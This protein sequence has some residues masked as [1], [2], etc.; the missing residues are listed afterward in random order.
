MAV[1][2][3]PFNLC[4]VWHLKDYSVFGDV[5]HL[6]IWLCLF[7]LH[8]YACAAHSI[9]LGY[10]PCYSHQSSRSRRIHGRGTGGTLI[11]SGGLGNRDV[12]M[13]RRK[14]EFLDGLFFLSLCDILASW[15]EW[16][17][18]K[19]LDHSPACSLHPSMHTPIC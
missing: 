7:V 10:V 6:F 12:D 4:M 15:E 18:L 3:C 9:V 2:T 14:S 1:V 13:E 17:L 11:R 8:A 5:I 16:R 19:C